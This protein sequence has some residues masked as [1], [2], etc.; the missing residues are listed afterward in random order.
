[1]RCLVLEAELLR[2]W[3]AIFLEVKRAVF[4]RGHCPRVECGF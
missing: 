1:M 4:I 2:I 3:G